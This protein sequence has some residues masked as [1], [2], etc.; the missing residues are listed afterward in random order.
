[1]DHR[2]EEYYATKK[3]RGFYKVREYRYAWIGSIHIVF[4][5]GEKE[6]FAAGLFREGALERI[7][8][9]IDKLHANSRKKI[10]R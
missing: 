2:L 4:S 10:G 7:F 3:Y 1:M 5:D 8:N 9:K 6:V